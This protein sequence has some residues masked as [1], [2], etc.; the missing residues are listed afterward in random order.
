[1]LIKFLANIS[2]FANILMYRSYLSRS[3]FREESRHI[4]VLQFWRHHGSQR[5]I[6]FLQVTRDT[7]CSCLTCWW[8]SHTDLWG[9]TLTFNLLDL[10]WFGGHRQ[11]GRR[12]HEMGIFLFCVVIFLRCTCTKICVWTA[13][14]LARLHGCKGLSKPSLFAYV[15]STL[16]TS[17]VPY[18]NPVNDFIKQS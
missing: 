11:P 18:Q 3:K 16:F 17:M 15:I 9:L 1:M 14:A 5:C 12:R 7:R 13:K 10:C 2:V 4:N 8:S 6:Q